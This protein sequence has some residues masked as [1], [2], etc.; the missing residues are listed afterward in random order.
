MRVFVSSY[1][2]ASI[3]HVLAQHPAPFAIERQAVENRQ[4]I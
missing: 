1:V 3:L 2:V 4:R